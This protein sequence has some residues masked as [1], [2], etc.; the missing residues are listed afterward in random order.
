M[1]ERTGVT[2]DQG[3]DPTGEFL[4]AFGGIALPHTVVL[5]AEGSVAALANRAIRD[6]ADLEALI[7]RAAP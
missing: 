2:F 5:D 4:A 1:V 3:R 7:A 6:R